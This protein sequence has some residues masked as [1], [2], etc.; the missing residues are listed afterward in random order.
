VSKTDSG[1]NKPPLAPPVYVFPL[2]TDEERVARVRKA[3]TLK[4]SR[5]ENSR[6]P[7]SGDDEKSPKV[8]VYKLEKGKTKIS[9][10]P[11]PQSA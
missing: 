2:L 11:Q 4:V 9:S 8:H 1:D 6:Q 3:P 5:K 7:S 10:I